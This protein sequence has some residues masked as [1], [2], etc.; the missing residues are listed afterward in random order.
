MKLIYLIIAWNLSTMV[1]FG[2]YMDLKSC[3]KLELINKLLENPDD[4]KNLITNSEFYS[5]SIMKEKD[6]YFQYKD[7]E[8]FDKLDKYLKNDLKEFSGQCV[9]IHASSW[10][11]DFYTFSYIG[12]NIEIE[13]NI[14][15]AFIKVN[16]K[17]F[18]KNISSYSIMYLFSESDTI[19][20][21]NGFK[22]KKL[23]VRHYVL[24]TQSILKSKV[25]YYI[26]YDYQSCEKE[27]FIRKI[28]TNPSNLDSILKNSNFTKKNYKF[29]KKYNTF[30]KLINEYLTKY[31]NN[32]AWFNYPFPVHNKSIDEFIYSDIK[33]DYFI[34][35]F[36]SER[37]GYNETHR[38]TFEFE[39]TNSKWELTD[40]RKGIE[41]C[42]GASPHDMI[43]PL[44]E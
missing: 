26:N 4:Y 27:I 41:V 7:G 10:E 40:I 34:V 1:C 17:W 28:L 11:A 29:K 23:P 37:S 14:T 35:N 42:M 20:F 16:S 19:N 2:E 39:L 24:R 3:E 25:K 9:M 30:Y 31:K 44:K 15:F 12:S 5:E 21:K 32:F 18:F 22:E 38:L 33:K 8:V 6:K 36:Y 43:K 13:P